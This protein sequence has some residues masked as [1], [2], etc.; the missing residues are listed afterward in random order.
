MIFRDGVLGLHPVRAL[1]LVRARDL[2]L[3]T[4]LERLVE[5]HGDRTLA[6]DVATG[7]VWTHRAAAEHVA[8]MAGAIAAQVAPGER[9]VI[10]T[11]N[12]IEQ[13]FAVLA[14][15]R[16]GAIPAPVNPQMTDDEIDHVVADSA[17]GLV[18]RDLEPLLDARPAEAAPADPADVAALFYTSGTT[19]KPKGVELTHRGLLGGVASAAA[20]PS[21]LHRDEAVVAL[22]VAHIMGFVVLLGLAGA[23]I[24]AYVLP[25]FHPDEVLDAIEQRR[26]TVFVGVPAMFR[27]LLDAGAE[28]RDLSSVRLWGSGADAMPAELAARFK[29]MG[30]TATLPLVGAVGEAMFAEGYGM[31]EAGGGV[32]V[33]LSPP[34][35]RAG[36]GSSLGLPLPGH[37]FR[38]VDED[39]N[40]VG[41]GSTG[42]LEVQGPG[43]LEGY[44]GSPEAGAAVL[45]DDGWLRTGD[46]VR[47]GVAGSFT[48]EGRAKDVLMHGGYSVYAL[49]VEQALEAHPDVVEAAVVGLP[50]PAK[51]EVPAAAVRLR[52]AAQLQPD[53]LITWSRQ[54]LS[55]YKA[56]RTVLVVDELPRG[57]TGKIQKDRVRDLF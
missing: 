44:W 52:P 10:A 39:G 51:G 35:L 54:H 34:G 3:G 22:P 2:T 47:K 33:K 20:W 36:L 18:V 50:D 24:P 9:V 56:P 53:E 26:A 19:G 11:P 17:A 21:T 49:E 48:F 6:T 12:G 23:G 55:A 25:G 15:A 28:N 46:L 45:T 7:R 38:V 42:E 37:R 57:G 41:T 32:A 27:R 43:V 14:V 13:V 5:V 31:V 40:E 16:A 1:R 29:S 30:A 4:Y 8:R